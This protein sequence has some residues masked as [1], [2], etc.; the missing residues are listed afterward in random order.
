[1]VHFV[2]FVVALGILGVFTLLPLIAAR[3]DLLWLP[4]A[5]TFIVIPLLDALVGGPRKRRTAA[6]LPAAWAR[7]L[8]RAQVP[9][10]LW[11]LLQAV[12]LVPELGALE[13][14]ILA[15][16]VGTVTGGV[17]ITV[18][19]ELGH[20]SSRL[21]RVLSRVLLLSVAYGHFYVEHNRGHHARVAT[22]DDPATAPR[23]MH[24]YRFIGRS[25]WG[26]LVHGWRLE[27]W[28]LERQ[29]RSAWHPANWVLTGSLL[30]VGA[31]LLVGAGAGAAAALFLA[32]QAVWAVILLEIVNYIEHY[33]LRRRVLPGGRPEPVAPHHSWNADFVVSN[34]LLFN[35]QLHSDH[36]AHVA[37]PFEALRSMPQAPQLPA[38]YPTMV[39]AAL[40][41]PLWFA[42]MDARVPAEPGPLTA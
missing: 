16:A 21:D 39:L 41:P 18:A 15:V 36:H 8:P 17:G 24:V 23:G 1:M 29:G 31:V 28:R 11:L 10:Q 25:L 33:G 37:R 13:V 40:V 7:W 42:L 38:G 12:L 4:L 14:T 5:V 9:L 34:L 20:R 27:A 22:A 19:H 6:F 3:I 35:L 32:L 26:S 2:R 30:S